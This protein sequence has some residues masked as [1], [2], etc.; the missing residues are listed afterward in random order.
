MKKEW[1]KREIFE[2]ISKKLVSREELS[3][4]TKM[5]LKGLKLLMKKYGQKE[6]DYEQP[7]VVYMLSWK[8]FKKYWN[9]PSEAPEKIPLLMKEYF[10]LCEEERVIRSQNMGILD[11]KSLE[12]S[13]NFFYTMILN[14]MKKEI[15]PQDIN[16][17]VK[18]TIM[19]LVD[20]EI[21]LKFGTKDRNSS[22]KVEEY[23]YGKD[24]FVLEKGIYR[25]YYDNTLRVISEKFKRDEIA[26]ILK[27]ERDSVPRVSCA[28]GGNFS[29]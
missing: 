9:S 28:G 23:G 19:P 10:Q 1:L 18:Q 20:L 4:L 6:I 22:S 29:H 27:K 14:A 15:F 7:D 3:K 13:L 16:S 21:I 25:I 26:A 12:E 5:Q 24:L 8:G 17:F 2:N 11:L